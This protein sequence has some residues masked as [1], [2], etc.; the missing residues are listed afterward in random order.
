MNKLEQR[1]H[2][3]PI[4]LGAKCLECPLY[5]KAIKTHLSRPV[6]GE[7]RR[8]NVALIVEAPGRNEEHEGRPLIGASGRLLAWSLHE[9]R[10][11]R[12]EVS[13][14]NTILC[15]PPKDFKPAQWKKA[16]EACRPRLEKELAQVNPKIIFAAGNRAL[17]VTTGKA[18]VTPWYGALLDSHYGSVLP[19][20]HPALV[21][22]KPAMMPI[23]VRWLKRAFDLASGDLQPWVWPPITIEGDYLGALEQLLADN[24]P[25]AVDVENAGD[26]MSANML[27]VGFGNTKRG[28][29]IPWSVVTSNL[30]VAMAMKAIL[31]HPTIPKIGHY[32]QHDALAL[33]YKG[34]PLAGPVEDTLLLH[35]VLAPQLS[36]KLT[37]VA[38][39]E[40]HAPRWK[41]EFKGGSGDKGVEVF[42]KADPLKLRAYNAKDAIMT[43]IIHKTM[44]AQL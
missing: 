32:L 21:L 43:A 14:H 39:F 27:C 31:E 2:C 35:A 16:I 20:V 18:N 8:A 11:T 13:I 25:I 44:K 40:T 17:Q 29:S 23:F 30:G 7:I 28:V 33:K 19:S 9:L 3:D 34:F 38:A 24:E 37:D 41:S 1:P 5:D 42:T 36:H 4:A 6:P 15:R 12:Q 22:R 26:P 10:K